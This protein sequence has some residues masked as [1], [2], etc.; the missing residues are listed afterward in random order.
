MFIKYL[1]SKFSLSLFL[2]F[3]LLQTSEVMAQKRSFYK[4]WV[5]LSNGEKVSGA[6][7]WATENGIGVLHKNSTDTLRVDREYIHT[8]KIRRRGVWVMDYGREHL[9]DLR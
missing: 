7:A 4:V 2:F 5:D 9:L 1:L 8:L 3:V 6:L